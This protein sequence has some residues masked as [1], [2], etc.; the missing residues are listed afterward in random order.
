M[1]SEADLIR[2]LKAAVWQQQAAIL[3][4]GN[5]I[6]TAL[7][8]DHRD[9][10]GFVLRYGLT[11]IHYGNKSL[12]TVERD[13][14]DAL[15]RSGCEEHIAHLMSE[16]AIR[17]REL[18][19]SKVNTCP[20]EPE[21]DKTILDLG[22][23]SGHVALQLA[24][25]LPESKVLIADVNDWRTEEAQKR[26][27][28][29]HV[30]NNEIEARS[31]LRKS[32]DHTLLLTV[33][34]HSNDPV[35]LLHE[36]LFVTKRR[37]TIIESVTQSDVEFMVGAWVDWFYNRVIHFNEDPAK[38]IP[39]PCNFRPTDGW[40]QLIFKLTGRWPTVSQDLGVFQDLNPEHHHL[41][42]CHLA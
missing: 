10:K 2:I 26:T 21:K 19:Y 5:G 28:F 23:G 12:A 42:V 3:H 29:F 18:L 40:R 20:I 14:H 7:G 9:A 27:E 11:A 36:A 39:V 15:I 13:A 24:N 31:A 1:N 34:H 33:L 16:R 32:V 22:G 38:K 17:L 30:R 4:R 6:L 8:M 25:A 37:I 35:R 41:F